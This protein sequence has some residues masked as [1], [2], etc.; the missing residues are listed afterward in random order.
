MR[1]RRGDVQEALRLAA[2]IL[3]TSVMCARAA[4]AQ[5]VTRISVDASD[6]QANALSRDPSVSADGRY[7]AFTS[8]A[9]NLVPNDTNGSDD[10]FVKD[11]VLHTI[12]RVSV[13][14]DGTQGVGLNETPRISANGR[15]V[16]FM[17]TMALAPEDTTACLGIECRDIYVH[18]LVSGDTTLV[19]VATD[20][21]Q[22]NRYSWHPAISGDGRYVAFE[23]GATNL[24]PDDT[25]GAFDIFVRD[26]VAGTTTRVSVATGGRQSGGGRLPSIS[27]DGQ[28]VLFTGLIDAGLVDA[29]DAVPCLPGGGC[30]RVFIHD[31]TNHV[32]TRVPLDHIWHRAATEIGYLAGLAS[33]AGVISGDGHS[34]ALVARVTNFPPTSIGY[35]SHDFEAVYERTT[36]YTT[37][38]AIQDGGGG[39]GNL[40]IS[41][42]GHVAAFCE[43][44]GQPPTNRLALNS[45][46]VRMPG[47]LDMGFTLP[48]D[49]GLLPDCLGVSLNATGTVTAFST[50]AAEAS[51]DSNGVQDIYAVD[52]D[53]DHDGMP[54]RWEQRFGLN[55]LDASDA[56][57]DPD[58]DG[59]TNLQEFVAGTHP[60][61]RY[62][63]YLAEG[64]SNDFFN[65][66]I[67]AIAPA[68]DAHLLVHYQ[69]EDGHVAN[70]PV[71]VSGH[72]DPRGFPLPDDM[73]GSYAT[74]IE[75]DEFVAVER[76]V[77]WG[78]ASGAGQP[79]QVYGSHA[80]RA[81]DAP[82]LTWYFAEGATHG[83]FDLFYLLQNP[84][85]TDAHVTITYL[86]PMPRPPIE[87]TYLVAAHSRRTIWV[88]HEPGLDET[89]VSAKIASDVPIL[90][91]RSM[92]LSTS[93]QAFAGG[94]GG[95]GVPEPD[96][97]WFVAEGATGAFFDLFY[98]IG[99]PSTQD[100]TITVTYLLPGGSSFDKSYVVGAQSRLTIAVD[101]ED[102]RLAST[103]VSASIASTNGVPI[104]V[105]RA[106]W[107]PSPNWY[108]GHVSA[109]SRDTATTW[110]LAGGSYQGLPDQDTYLLVA[111]P[112]T[113]SV[114]VTFDLQG[115]GY[116]GAGSVPVQCAS[117]AIVLPAHSRQTVAL[118]SLCSAHGGGV[119]TIAIGGTITS[120]GGGIVVERSTYWSTPDQFWAAGSSTLLTKMP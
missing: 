8:S 44:I 109:A 14:S 101:G 39:E 110:V 93:S 90:A 77:T 3:A 74:V 55:P 82:A 102:P 41:A 76:T 62:T 28:V 103:D 5:S 53:T 10:I 115:A 38:L 99:N 45:Y 21:T 1:R 72:S 117:P 83:A 16:A 69:S 84:S 66:A 32:T 54:D 18:D 81:I 31:R 105:E 71:Y 68:H 26:R 95:A 25:N 7:I 98:T 20:G 43:G 52:I 36:G 75:S 70:V 37:L 6:S 114:T 108:E 61:A 65:T 92:Y 24:V 30:E 47:E 15:F 86:L 23:S 112:G 100:A 63:R 79:R 64:V 34:V 29:P 85:D 58:G 60:K 27:D 88:D 56:V 96:T 42:N 17:S 49:R 120:V 33:V 22:A 87:L 111:N 46:D 106:M 50:T 51:D 11:V 116:D 89:D 80:E 13:R 67:V 107:W 2:L 113:S 59:Q 94:T 4:P 97:H 73:R 119:G 9:T 118:T 12:T 48:A 19:S 57:L 91:E 78:S 35:L 40:A 104:V